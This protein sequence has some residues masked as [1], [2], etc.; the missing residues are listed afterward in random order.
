[1]SSP[2]LSLY[3]STHVAR[4]RVLALLLPD[5]DVP[6]LAD[7]ELR[8]ARGAPLVVLSHPLLRYPLTQASVAGRVPARHRHRPAE[9]P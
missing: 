4:A 9:R 6:Q 3:I 8:L 7:F 5:E 2:Q 1:M